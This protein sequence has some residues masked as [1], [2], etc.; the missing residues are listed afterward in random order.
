MD[1]MPIIP[2]INTYNIHNIH[3]IIDKIKN[4]INNEKVSPKYTVFEDNSAFKKRITITR[5]A[6]VKNLTSK[7]ARKL[8]IYR[9]CFGT[10]QKKVQCLAK[11]TVGSQTIMVLIMF[12]KL[13][14]IFKAP[15]RN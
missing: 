5:A 1:S 12:K 15:V 13:K 3:E 6:D 10:G 8:E 11:N 7:I 4:N 14:M 9:D 2:R